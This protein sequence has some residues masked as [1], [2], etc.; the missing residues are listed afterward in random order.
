MAVKGGLVPFMGWPNS[1]S[2]GQRVMVPFHPV[3]FEWSLLVLGVVPFDAAIDNCSLSPDQSMVA[4][5]SVFRPMRGVK[6]R[7]LKCLIVASVLV[8][9]VG[10]ANAVTF[11]VTVGPGCSGAC[12]VGTID[13]SGGAVTSVNLQLTGLVANY[14]SIVASDPFSGTLWELTVADPITPPLAPQ[15][16]AIFLVTSVASLAGY[17][18][19]GIF[20]VCLPGNS[21]GELGCDNAGLLQGFLTPT[22]A[23]PLPAALPLFA[24]GAGLIGLLA[25]R[26][27]RKAALAA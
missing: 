13:V 6:M 18:G 12:L 16:L 20:N 14:T 5:G 17:D 8:L 2:T 27:K 24:G 23:T 7:R 11:D 22:S 9:T 21:P 4:W 3:H 26:R 19:G 10:A 1:A 25:R 15:E